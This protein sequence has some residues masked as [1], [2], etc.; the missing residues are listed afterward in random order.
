MCVL[1]L[2]LDGQVRGV[3]RTNRN[4]LE[5]EKEMRKNKQISTESFVKDIQYKF[6]VMAVMTIDDVSRVALVSSHSSLWLWEPCTLC[7]VR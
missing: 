1:C 6:D 4:G 2:V 3:Y 7:S 5:K